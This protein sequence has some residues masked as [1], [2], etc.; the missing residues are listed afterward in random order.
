M[1]IVYCDPKSRMMNGREG[2]FLGLELKA[3][4]GKLV[5]GVSGFAAGAR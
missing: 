3:P 5:E 4:L 1:S 2:V